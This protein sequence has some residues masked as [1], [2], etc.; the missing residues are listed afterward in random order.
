MAQYL[1]NICQL[2]NNM[3]HARVFQLTHCLSVEF[4]EVTLGSTF[5]TIPYV[6]LLFTKNRCKP[7][8]VTLLITR[9]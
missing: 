7:V 2:S 8:G 4:Q 6:T 3:A 5:L 9:C 1:S